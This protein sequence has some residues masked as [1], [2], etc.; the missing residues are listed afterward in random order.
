MSILTQLHKY[1]QLFASL[2]I[3]SFPFVL[4]NTDRIKI[5]RSPLEVGLI[6]FDHP[7]L[8][9]HHFVS[10]STAKLPIQHA[11][12]TWI[13]GYV[14]N[15]AYIPAHKELQFFTT[16]KR[17]KHFQEYE[18]RIDFGGHRDWETVGYGAGHGVLGSGFFLPF[19]S[20]EKFG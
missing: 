9:L 15:H 2:A 7:K 8:D 6:S 10:K 4:T 1:Q 16:T 18:T 3:L 17:T 11:L 13:P 19:S 5:R 20:N 14:R 12:V